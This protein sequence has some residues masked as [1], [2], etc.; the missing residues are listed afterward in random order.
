MILVSNIAM[1]VQAVRERI[2]AAAR[3][4]GRRPE[5]I[6]LIAVTK[7]RSVAEIQAALAAGVTDLGENR[8]QELQ[9]KVP[10]VGPG[11]RWHLIGSLQ[12]N[13]ARPALTL[14]HLIHSLDRPGLAEEVNRL[15][16][17]AGRPAECLVQV[18]VAGEA[19]KHGIAPAG[20]FAFLEVVAALGWIQVRGLMTI[21]PVAADP[22]TVRP[23]F[24][25]LRELAERA[26]GLGLPRVEMRYLSMGMSGDFVAAIAE[27]ANLVRI[28]TAIFGE[29]PPKGMG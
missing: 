18:N 20:L 26:A 8:V 10:A 4:A 3:V 22:E 12:T 21:A 27:G 29:R 23:V 19:S 5:E 15:A 9:A 1:N 6:T 14:A 16:R 7:T 24:A 17:Q 28:G 13:K 2:A 25:R 11:P